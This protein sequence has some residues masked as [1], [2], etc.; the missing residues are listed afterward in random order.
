MAVTETLVDSLGGYG[1]KAR[2]SDE[3]RRTT[4]A[5]DGTNISTGYIKANNSNTWKDT[6]IKSSFSA[7]TGIT[8]VSN[9]SDVNLHAIISTDIVETPV[10]AGTGIAITDNTTDVSFATKP[11]T[12]LYFT[13]SPSM[14]TSSSLDLN[15]TTGTYTTY[16][17]LT[18][19]SLGTDNADGITGLNSN[20][21]YRCSV[22]VKAINSGASDAVGTVTAPAWASGVTSTVSSSVPAGSTV[23]FQMDW[24]CKGVTTI[25]PTATAVADMSMG[26]SEFSVEEVCDV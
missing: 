9:A 15:Q 6:G 25:I 5:S 26:I 11:D 17:T 19:S 3:S 12:L 7:G 13:A 8:I 4:Y 23:I 16:T 24:Y 2:Y 21:M 1:I 20:K 10:V 22:K 14:S 18:N